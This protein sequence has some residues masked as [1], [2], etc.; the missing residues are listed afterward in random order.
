M[1]ALLEVPRGNLAV[2]ADLC[3]AA[4][5]TTGDEQ[6]GTEQLRFW[7][8][9]ALVVQQWARHHQGLQ[10]DG[11]VVAACARR[12]L[13]W[14]DPILSVLLITVTALAALESG[15]VA[16]ARRTLGQARTDR[17]IAGLGLW[18]L[19][20]LILDGYLSV[21]HD[22]NRRAELTIEELAALP[23]PAETALMRAL[24]LS[25]VGRVND[26][27]TTIAPITSGAVASLSFTYPVALSLEA[28]LYEE[29]GKHDDAD[30]S[31]A[32]ALGAAE[33]INGLRLFTTLGPAHQ[34]TLVLR[35][36]A[37]QPRN[38]WAATVAAYLDGHATDPSDHAYAEPVRT[39]RRTHGIT[40]DPAEQTVSPLTRRELEVLRL[41]NDGASLTQIATRLYVSANTSKTHLRSIRR[42]LGVS[43]TI[44]AAAIARRSGWL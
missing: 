20:K 37:S 7:Q 18:R 35:A 39:E 41:V 33:P 30:R 32:R 26:A 21:S 17:R 4:L 40:P 14:A 34:H 11:A 42:K 38:R 36:A 27:L 24:Q 28:A 22:D 16:T 3:H 12:P 2:A 9:R 1:L 29:I 19:P 31:M 25:H 15:D 43:R 13:I 10:I 44:E 6:D 8:L 23:A 5:A